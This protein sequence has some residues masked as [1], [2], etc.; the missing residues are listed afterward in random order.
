MPHFP[1]EIWLNILE[2]L[3]PSDV[4]TSLHRASKQLQ[5][6]AEDILTREPLTKFTVGL[7]FV[8][9]WHR[10]PGTIAFTFKDLNK[11]NPEYA[12]FASCIVYPQHY[13]DCAM[14]IWSHHLAQG[15]PED[16]TRGWRVQH[17][18]E[19]RVVFMA[20]PNLAVVDG[21]PGVWVNWRELF[22]AYWG[23]PP[24]VCSPRRPL[25][26]ASHAESESLDP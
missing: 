3:S 6:C 10:H 11:H 20:L 12:C 8:T 14:Q 25:L 9:S 24:V 13:Y 26:D 16:N 17:G 7:G 5:R 1:D 18:Y 21:E 19:G 4:W 23:P 22:N 2:Y 15:F